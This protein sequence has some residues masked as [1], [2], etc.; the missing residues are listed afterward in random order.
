[1]LRK[2]KK[3][4]GEILCCSQVPLIFGSLLCVAYVL[5]NVMLHFIMCY[6]PTILQ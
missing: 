2:V 1:M 6:T 5:K 3:T 4:Q